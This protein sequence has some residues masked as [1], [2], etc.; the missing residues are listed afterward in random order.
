MAS[1][2]LFGAVG[3]G[4]AAILFLFL[5][6]L[7]LT[8]WRGR[9]QG[10][11]LVAASFT[12]AVWAGGL[13]LQAGWHSLPVHWL[14][15]LE[16]LRDLVWVMFLLAVLEIQ[17][18]ATPRLRR[19]FL[20]LRLTGLLLAGLLV[21]PFED[22]GAS[23]LALPGI[24]FATLRLALQVLFPVAVL[25]LLEQ[26]YRNTPWE[27][28]WGVKFLCLGIGGLFAYDFYFYA[29]SSAWTST[30]GLRGGRSTPWWFRC[31]RCRLPET[32][33]GRST[34]SYPARSSSTPR[35]S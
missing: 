8:G 4:V 32:L 21:L 13:A 1:L 18:E 24:D 5:A 14:W 16:A 9:M 11:L 10:G 3:Y 23:Q 7:L 33:S 6:V 12:T 2:D 19:I 27:H 29:N 15:V 25:V 30:S 20:G 22:L 26:V 34:C 28:R 35:P 31:S 17:L